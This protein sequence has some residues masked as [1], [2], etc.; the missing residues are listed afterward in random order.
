[1]KN[2]DRQLLAYICFE[3]SDRIFIDIVETTKNG[4]SYRYEGELWNRGHL[5]FGRELCTNQKGYRCKI[6]PL[7]RNHIPE[8]VQNL[9]IEIAA[10]AM[11][12]YTLW[13]E[14]KLKP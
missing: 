1:M 14:K 8:W 11:Q 7:N 2:V 6:V 10:N 13:Q 9:Q 3:N 4:L 5:F 12:R